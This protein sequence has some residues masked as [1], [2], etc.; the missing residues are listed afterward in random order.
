MHQKTMQT[1]LIWLLELKLSFIK[2]HKASE[3]S[4]K[5]INSNAKLGRFTESRE[6][7]S[8]YASQYQSIFLQNRGKILSECKYMHV[9]IGIDSINQRS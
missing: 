9:A 1:Y 7:L 2:L 3:S 6:F 8:C 4:L 5:R